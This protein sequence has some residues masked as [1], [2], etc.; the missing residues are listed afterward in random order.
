MDGVARG[1][2]DRN[3]TSRSLH[4]SSG[5]AHQIARF[6]VSN[7]AQIGSG[8][9]GTRGTPEL[10]CKMVCTHATPSLPIRILA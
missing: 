7:C 2:F 9:A 1:H 3:A 10:I 6:Y 5:T 8:V 4:F